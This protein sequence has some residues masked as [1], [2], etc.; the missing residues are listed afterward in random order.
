MAA[1]AQSAEMLLPLVYD[2]L[3]RLAQRYFRDEPADHTL[4]PTAL[5]HEVCLRLIGDPT[6]RNRAQILSAAARSM[7][8][9]LIDHARR[10]RAAVHGGGRR[11]VPLE[12]A[13][14]RAVDRDA[15]LVALDEALDELA[16]IDPELSRLIE[17]R[18][19]GGFGVEETAQVLGV[20]PATV[21]RRWTLAKGWLHRRIIEGDAA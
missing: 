8:H 21:K 20:S 11:K 14:D 13:A 5:V 16:G 10:R 4:Q 3:R 7:R 6:V 15:Y 19:F 2:E 17:L 1:P 12:E 9:L 18:F